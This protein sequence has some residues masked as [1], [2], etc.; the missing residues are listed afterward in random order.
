MATVAPDDPLRIRLVESWPRRTAA[1]DMSRHDW[2]AIDAEVAPALAPA[3]RSSAD[4]VR[5][6]M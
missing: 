3:A 5:S 6:K 1:V 4:L 2:P